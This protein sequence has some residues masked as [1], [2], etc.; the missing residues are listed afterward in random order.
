MTNYEIMCADAEFWLGDMSA[1]EL[2]ET[3]GGDSGIARIAYL[4]TEYEVKARFCLD[5]ENSLETRSLFSLLIAEAERYAK[6]VEDWPFPS[7]TGE[8]PE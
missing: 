2:L 4:E 8:I 6:T 1:K 7:V 5:L 3:I